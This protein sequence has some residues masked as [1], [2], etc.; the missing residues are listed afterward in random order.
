MDRDLLE[1][2]LTAQVLTLA[3][4]MELEHTV[5]GGTISDQTNAAIRKIRDKQADV[6]RK[7]L[8]PPGTADS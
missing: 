4:L 1:K 7:L 8:E 2:L 3:R 6:I 5:K